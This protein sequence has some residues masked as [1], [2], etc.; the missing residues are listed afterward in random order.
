LEILFVETSAVDS[1]LLL[2][3]K[4]LVQNECLVLLQQG[5]TPILYAY[6]DWDKFCRHM[7][8]HNTSRMSDT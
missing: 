7:P 1:C 6:N 3:I 8:Y 5:R 4:L 2:R